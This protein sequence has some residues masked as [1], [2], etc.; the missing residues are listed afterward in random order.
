MM[1]ISF[2]QPKRVIRPSFGADDPREDKMNSTFVAKQGW[3]QMNI[4]D[5]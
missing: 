5:E 2:L 1:K 4:L 3:V